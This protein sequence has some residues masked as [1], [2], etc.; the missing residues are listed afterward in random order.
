MQEV[1]EQVLDYLKGIWI[2]RRFIII[3]TWLICPLGWY[4]VAKMPNVYESQARVYVDTQSLLRPLLRGLTIETDPQMQIR[5]M[6]KT[7]LSRP[8]LEKIARMSDLDIQAKN[9]SEFDAIIEGLKNDIKISQSGRENIFTLSI[10]DS[11]AERAKTIVQSSLT[12]FIE[13]TLGENRQDSD[14]AQ[15]FLDS[16]IKE[17]ESR[18]VVA[19]NKLK[20]FKQKYNSV[21]SSD[22][23]NFY[24]NLNAEKTRLREVELELKETQ[25]QLDSANAQLAGEEPVVGLFSQN[26]IQS[27]NNNLTTSYD[28]RIAQLEATLDGLL[29]KYTKRHPEVKEVT[30]R[31]E[32]LQKQRQKE[33]EDYYSSIK[34]QS[35]TSSFGSIDANPVYQDMKIQA[36][37][38]ANLVASLQ[39]RAE[40]YR[41]RVSELEEKIYSIP[42]IE[43]QLVALNRGY[44]ITKG[45]YE[46]LLNRKET[47][48]LAQQADETS[49]K[50][51]FRVVDP[52]MAAN[53]PSGPPRVLFFVGVFIVGLG[54]GV[55]ISL[56]MSQINP[57]VTSEAQVLK[58]IG[59]PVFGVVSAS[60]NLGLQ[61]WHRRKTMIFMMSNAALL[62]VLMAFIS[63]FTFP[64]FFSLSML[65]G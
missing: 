30:R 23:G 9:D 45:K 65:R 42:E 55:A 4:F 5:L 14:T 54:V 36:N 50:I 48:Q 26:K 43:A 22:N 25:T 20:E 21:L 28:G 64:E 41:K 13:N 63:Y 2:K 3:S 11:D 17:Y 18:L 8:N 47:A 33:L 35:E 37:R 49:D 51:Q 59:L 29:V 57:V 16:Q 53:L 52:P 44:D 62:L 40:D 60:E 27:P 12:V 10:E 31:L 56:L 24:S 7:L 34:D 46:E 58:E 15:R 61:K 32:E 1:L 6:V 39:V 38:L 19:E